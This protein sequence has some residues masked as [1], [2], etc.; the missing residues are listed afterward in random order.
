MSSDSDISWQVLRQIVHDWIGTAAE[1]VEVKP[2]H[3]GCINTT[4]ALTT[5]AGD[6]AVLKISAHRVDRSYIDEAYQLNVLRAVGLPTP[7]VY[8]CTVGTLDSPYSYLLMQHIDGV[9]LAEARERCSPEEIDH[10][11]IHLADLTLQLHSQTNSTYTRVIDGKRVEFE[12][13]AQFYRAVYDPIWKEAQK[14]PALPVK[15]R[16]QIGKVHDKLDR[17]LAHTDCP[18][19][20]HWDLWS[21]NVMARPDENGRWWVAAIL[22]PNCKYGHAEAEIAYMELFNTVTPAFLRAYQ[23]SRRLP[24]EYHAIRKPIYQLYPLVNHIN[25]FGQAYVKP[26]M[27]IVEKIV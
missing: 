16:K 9:S 13:W 5:K 10:L 17:L 11:Q 3:G 8:S 20:V 15:L 4:L 24:P 1:L 22:D 25:L 14:H 2:L 21:T 19:L 12:N 23:A 18:R 27:A 7:Q 6:K 26:L